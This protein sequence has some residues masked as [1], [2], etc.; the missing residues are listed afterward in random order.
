MYQKC[1]RN[2]FGVSC[3]A[4]LLNKIVGSLVIGQMFKKLFGNA[5]HI[6]V[7]LWHQEQGSEMW[8]S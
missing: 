2:C 6:C 7:T 5:V 3:Y 4:V 1:T 8:S